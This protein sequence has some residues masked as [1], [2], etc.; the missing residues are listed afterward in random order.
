LIPPSKIYQNICVFSTNVRYTKLNVLTI[1]ISDIIF[2]VSRTQ[3]IP[4][5]GEREMNT[6][7]RIAD[8]ISANGIKQSFIVE[9]TGLN[10]NVIS[11]IL[12][13]SRKMSADEYAQICK[14][15]NKTPNDF[16]LIE[17]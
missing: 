13:N 11:G 6:Q 4:N 1:G 9:K 15:L 5:I 8:Y 12:T 10:K 2:S 3:T 16:M 14:A 17:D 7:K